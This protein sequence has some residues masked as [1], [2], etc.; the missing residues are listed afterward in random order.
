[1]N[2][3]KFKIIVMIVVFQMT[4]ILSAALVN[5]DFDNDKDK[6]GDSGT[7]TGAAALGSAGDVWNGVA[8]NVG[9]AGWPGDLAAGSLVDSAGAATGLTLS[10]D[11]TWV[12]GAWDNNA[13]A[14]TDA[15]A[16]MGD[17]INIR[18]V[19]GQQNSVDVTI[20]GL[21]ASSAYTL[22]LYGCG[23]AANQ[24]AHFTVDAVTQS[25]LGG[26]AVPLASPQHYVTFTGN[27][28]A[29]GDIFVTWTQDPGTWSAFNGFQVDG[30]VVPEPATLMLLG[31]GSLVMAARKRR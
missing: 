22:V 3:K 21:A 5:V 23:D 4:G 9:D 24:L 19:S 10:I 12:N 30:T 15:V 11:P 6:N 16:L 13:L 26:A 1:M 17:Y 27:A 31:L 2:G 8:V 7:M 25:T 29:N 18:A 20:G 28:D 14:A